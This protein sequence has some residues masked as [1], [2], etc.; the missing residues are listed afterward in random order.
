MLATLGWIATDLGA[1]FPGEMYQNVTT[2]QAHDA[3]VQTGIMQPFLAAI[4]T[5]EVYAGWLTNQGWSERVKRD[6]GDYFLGKNFLPKDEEKARD[7]K[8]KEL[9]NGRLAML[10]FGG[11]VTEAVITGKTWPML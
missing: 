3:M 4:G 9:E 2:I 7:M 10:A 8:L 6:A 11:I 1:R 5:F